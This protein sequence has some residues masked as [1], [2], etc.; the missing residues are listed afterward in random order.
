[1]HETSDKRYRDQRQTRA[2]YPELTRYEQSSQEEE[3]KAIDAHRAVKSGYEEYKS[4]P[5]NLT[6]HGPQDTFSNDLDSEEDDSESLESNGLEQGAEEEDDLS[7]DTITESSDLPEDSANLSSDPHYYGSNMS[8]P[9]TDHQYR[10]A[11]L[12][13]SQRY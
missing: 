5:H 8:S 13:T 4:R 6:Y 12:R 9:Q 1:M 3:K 10:G 2:Q 11:P 7:S